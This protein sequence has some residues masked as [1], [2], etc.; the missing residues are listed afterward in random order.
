[1]Y[2][3]ALTHNSATETTEY[4]IDKFQVD[5]VCSRNMSTDSGSCNASL[6]TYNKNKESNCWVIQNEATGLSVE[7]I[8][9]IQP[10]TSD[11]YLLD[12]H[13]HFNYLYLLSLFNSSSGNDKDPIVRKHFDQVA[14]E[15]CKFPISSAYVDYSSV[16]QAINFQILFGK[17]VE[18]AIRKE[19]DDDLV[20]FSISYENHLVYMNMENINDFCIHLKAYLNK[21]NIHV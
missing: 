7:Y 21:L 16:N 5:F 17:D 1:M 8:P 12:R 4:N 10:Y 2:S 15:L 3:L 14:T 11:S 9:K 13:S 6:Y 18:F 19:F 20:A